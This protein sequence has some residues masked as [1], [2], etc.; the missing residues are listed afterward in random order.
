MDIV[1]RLS[2]EVESVGPY[3]YCV[4]TGHKLSEERIE[5]AA[6]ITRLREENKEL[7]HH[8]MLATA[9]GQEEAA[10]HNEASAEV[11]RLMEENKRM[12]EALKPFA[13]RAGKLDGYWLDHDTCWSPRYGDTAVTIAD[14]RRA[15][16]TLATT[17]GEVS[18]PAP[19]TWIGKKVSDITDMK[20]GDVVW[21]DENGIV[22]RFMRGGE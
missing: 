13:D 9:F 16:A 12:R 11:G 14:L 15:Y 17:G 18:K 3:K 2:T 22:T 20:D 6:E 8:L 4:K 1:E 5:A 7:E 10:A 21:E 19:E